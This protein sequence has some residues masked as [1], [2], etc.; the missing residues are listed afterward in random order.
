MKLSIIIPVYNV[1]QYLRK[2][3]DSVLHQDLA[4][5]EY[6]IILVND[7]STDGSGELAEMLATEINTNFP[8]H[9]VLINQENKGLSEARNAGMKVANGDYIQFVDS[10]D[11]IEPDVLGTLL[12]KV[13]EEHLDVLRFDYQ[14]VRINSHNDYE[15]FEPNK[16]PRKVDNCSDVV[17]GIHYLNNRM[18]YA[19]YAVQ[20]L[21]K[22]ELLLPQCDDA[23]MFT[24]GMYFEDTE[25]TPRMLIRAKRVNATNVIAYN[26]LWREGSITKN[27]AKQDKIIADKI[28]LIVSLQNTA[29]RVEER[30]WFE[31]MISVSVISI[32]DGLNSYDW[33]RIDDCLAML[34]QKNVFPLQVVKGTKHAKRKADIINISPKLYCW[35]QKTICLFRNVIR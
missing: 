10:D 8:N 16:H 20:F 22:K 31:G 17:N 19:C 34:K 11:Y 33:K 9:C 27:E 23:C 32:I 13:E 29:S 14:N 2:C 1:K 5:E 7:G 25:W 21:I 6:E 24:R 18:S 4:H 26:Y 12:Q 28:R 30:T 15:V 3:V 35:T